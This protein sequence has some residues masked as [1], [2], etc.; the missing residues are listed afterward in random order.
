MKLMSISPSRIKTFDRCLFKYWMTYHGKIT[1]KSNFG[2]AHGSMLHDICEYYVTGEDKNWLNRLFAAYAGRL[3]TRDKYG[4][5]VRLDSPLKI[6]KDADYKLQKPKCDICPYASEDGT[7][8][9]SAE[10]LDSLTGCPKKLFE[11]SVNTIRNVIASYEDSTWPFVLKDPDNKIIGAEYELNINLEGT[12]VPLIGIMDLVIERDP[13]TI[14]IIDYKFGNWTQ[15][16]DECRE[17]IQV[18][19]YSM[20]ARKEFIDDINKKGYKYKNIFLT[21]DYFTGNPVTLAYT[22]EEDKKTEDYVISKIREILSTTKVSRV[23]G[24]K[25]F[26]WQCK[27]MCD[28]TVCQREW[29]GEFE[30]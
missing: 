14:E 24:N 4:K 17:D 15:N 26:D 30:V 2:A 18:K 3:E 22:K 29:K 27:S 28:I 16:Y 13:E 12:N 19:I 1:L 7:C 8:L 11:N 10:K 9:I 21:F 20:A 5:A 23:V 25:D 6:A